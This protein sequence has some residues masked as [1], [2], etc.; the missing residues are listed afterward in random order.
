MPG[1]KT[2]PWKHSPGQGTDT[3]KHSPGQKIN[4]W[5]HFPGQKT[6]TW[7][8]VGIWSGFASGGGSGFGRDLV[9]I[10][11]R[12]RPFT[13]EISNTLRCIYIYIYICMYVYMYVY[14][15]PRCN[16]QRPTFQKAI[17]LRL[18]PS[19]PLTHP[20]TDKLINSESN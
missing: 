2:N 1:Q 10:S 20:Q 16:S 17:S 5:K 3:W 14:V 6:N 11:T 9:G 15:S 13:L 19:F 8:G 7:R 18:H 12:S 4:T